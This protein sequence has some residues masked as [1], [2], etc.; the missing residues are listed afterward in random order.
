MDAFM[1]LSREAQGVLVG[2]A[3]FIIVSF[4]DWQSATIGP[5]SVGDNLWHGFGIIVAL[6]AIILLVWEIFRTIEVKIDLRGTDPGVISTALALVLGILTV[7]IFLDWSQIRS[8]PEYVGT[9]LAI[10]IAVL[11]VLRARKEGVGMPAMPSGISVGSGGA[12][13]ASAGAPAPAPTPA[14]PA[15]PAPAADP[16]P[17]PVAEQAEDPAPPADPAPDAPAEA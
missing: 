13:A 4:F 2:T 16:A 1:K 9:L 8:W 11:A 12:A 5:Y 10:G 17:A 14:P 15:P 7:I 6:I 3:L